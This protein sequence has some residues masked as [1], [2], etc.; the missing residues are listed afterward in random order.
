MT[1]NA[2]IFSWDMMGIE[3]IIPITEYE[4]WDKMN[5]WNILADRPTVRNPLYSI[6]Q[7]LVLRARANS[8]RHYEIYAIDCNESLDQKFWEENWKEN[9]Q[10]CADLVREHGVK[11]WSDRVEENQI[12]IR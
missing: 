6:I 12:V 1:T 4:E 8:Q 11:I 2:F 7:R 10:W 3:A 9:P 5:T